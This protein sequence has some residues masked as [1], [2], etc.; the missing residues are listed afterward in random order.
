MGFHKP[1]REAFIFSH[2]QWLFEL[3]Q[4]K[5]HCDMSTVGKG[6]PNYNRQGE[7]PPIIG[8]NICERIEENN[9]RP[10]I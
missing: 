3:V 6:E 1:T 5:V 7:K 8:L 4:L 2:G 9:E 10:M